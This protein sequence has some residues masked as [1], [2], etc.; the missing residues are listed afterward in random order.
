MAVLVVN[1]ADEYSPNIVNFN[2]KQ[3]GIAVTDR[4][5]CHAID[6]FD[7]TTTYYKGN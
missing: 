5:N 6:L 3:H 1:F 4:D 2:L 7:G